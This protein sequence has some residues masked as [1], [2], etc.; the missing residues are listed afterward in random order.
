M[1]DLFPDGDR[2]PNRF[3]R[4][5]G[6]IIRSL[7]EAAGYSQTQLAVMIQRRQATVSE[8]ESGKVL[9]DVITLFRCALIFRKSLSTLIPVPW[10]D[11]LESVPTGP[12]QEEL[13]RQINRLPHDDV[14]K[15]LI[16]ITA[17]ADDVGKNE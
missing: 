5:Q 8:I 13:I 12:Q 2:P 4:E 6:K 15:V 3:T 14:A 10:Q 11:K 17:L 9:M 1:E 16:Q 7:R